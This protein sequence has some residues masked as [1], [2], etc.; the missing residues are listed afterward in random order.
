[1]IYTPRMVI[2]ALMHPIGMR[3]KNKAVCTKIEYKGFEISI[4]MD[5]SHGDGD[6]FRSDIRVYTAPGAVDGVEC[7]SEFLADG[8]SMLYGD[9]ETLL[10]VMKKIESMNRAE[11]TV[12]GQ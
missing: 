1:M 5:S 10:R 7:T 3:M 9:A 4:A 11:R 8:E 12:F 6:L 2:D